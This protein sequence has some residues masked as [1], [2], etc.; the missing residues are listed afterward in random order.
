MAQAELSRHQ[1]SALL[2]PFNLLAVLSIIALVAASLVAQADAHFY[3]GGKQYDRHTVWMLVGGGMYLW[4]EFA[5]I[6]KAA[7]VKTNG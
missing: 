5:P 3:A 4:R 6:I 2:E 1:R 7:I